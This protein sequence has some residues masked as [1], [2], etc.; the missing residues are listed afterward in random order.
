[1]ANPMMANSTIAPDGASAST[2]EAAR[3]RAV[4]P[5]S[6]IVSNGTGL[7]HLR[8]AAAELAACGR[9]AAFLTGAYP[10]PGLRRLLAA[11]AL[12]R[13]PAAGRLLA[14]E[15]SIPRERVH[16]LWLCEPLVQ[17]ATAARRLPGIGERLGD[18]GN[19][20]GRSLYGRAAR[21]AVR[22]QPAAPG[23]G[24]YHY[25]A[26]FGLHSVPAAAARGYTPLCEHSIVHPRLLR[27]LVENGGRVPEPGA[28]RPINANW[29]AILADIEQA[30][31][32]LANSD[33]VRETFLAEG[34]PGDRVHARQGRRRKHERD[35]D[36]FHPD[37]GWQDQ[38]R[39]RLRG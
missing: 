36:R 33:F 32:V 37:P 28:A 2:V 7:F 20:L 27:Y 13:I 25:R 1:M 3:R 23:R 39:H 4:P 11:R 8:V 38:G 29:S 24:I 19:R 9:L 10:T 18:W 16:A 26:G 15:A 6:V 5:N 31:H 35:R 12:R 17:S 21:A 14:R 30:R 22:R 34:W